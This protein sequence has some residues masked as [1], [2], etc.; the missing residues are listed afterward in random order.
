MPARAP[1]GECLTTEVV[2][3]AIQVKNLVM[4]PARIYWAPYGTA[5]PADATVTG[6]GWL[7]PPPA[8]WL[9]LGGTNGGCNLEIDTTYTAKVVDQIIMDAGATLTDLKMSVTA[10]LAEISDQNMAVGLNGIIESGQG[11]GYL[12]MEIMDGTYA[13]QPQYSALILDGWGPELDTGAPTLR[14]SIVRKVL[15]QAK[16]SL[17]HDRK[18][19]QK[20]DTTWQAYFVGEGIRPVHIVTATA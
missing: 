17:A 12:T 11:E 2:T 18:T 13:S 1:P 9:D 20:I 10:P 6:D 15:S 4:G 3:L 5:E 7:V 14:R 19:Q 8:P 16:V